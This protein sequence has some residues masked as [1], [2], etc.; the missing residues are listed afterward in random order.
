MNNVQYA[1]SYLIG[2]GLS[3]NA[4]AGVV[5]NLK[6]ES[7]VDPHANQ[8]GGPGMGIAQ[9]SEGG[10]WD[11]LKAWAGNRDI[12]SLQTQLDFL[13]H[14]LQTGY[15][16]VLNALQNTHNMA[17]ATRIFMTQFEI[18]ADTSASAVQG[19]VALA[20]DV[21][22]NNQET[23]L[24]GKQAESGGGG[25]GGGGDG[26][27]KLKASDFGFLQEFLDKHPSVKNLIDQA[28]NQE[29]SETRFLA[30]LK[31]TK[32][33]EKNSAAE[34]SW[35]RLVVEDPSEAKR[36]ED[37]ARERIAML[38]R[39]MGVDLDKQQLDNFALR[40][41]RLG[42]EDFELQAMIGAKFSMKGKGATTGEAGTTLDQLR[43]MADEY[44][45]NISHSA[46]RKMTSNVLQGDMTVQGLEDRFRQ[47]A[48]QRYPS[49]RDDLQRGYTVREVSD[50]Y[51]QAA[52]QVL[53][54][55][56]EMMDMSDRKWAAFLQSDEKK[57]E[58]MSIDEW[59]AHVKQDQ[60]YGYNQSM[61]AMND[62]SSFITAMGQRMGA[63]G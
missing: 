5:G 7:N 14:E 18:P 1:Y 3:P 2:K 37:V 55:P 30:E 47:K 24:N 45:V 41:V 4:A 35:T 61:Q 36:Q 40:A 49:L 21:R 44:G 23:G 32:W 29:W 28:V 60:K 13:W 9:W 39:N 6:A 27:S 46:L 48:M 11:S 34:R 25:G 53:G 43:T 12:F 20:E 51:L 58:P 50:D 52:S 31:Q 17:E 19:R 10:R 57:K 22:Q 33:W 42:L 56:T 59:V 15:G 63:V 26:D 8:S 54:M 62:A 38:A 16:Q